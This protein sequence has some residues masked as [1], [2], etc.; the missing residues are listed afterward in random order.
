L[1]K[2]FIM[3]NPG[4]FFH[5]KLPTTQSFQETVATNWY[6]YNEDFGFYA[7]IAIN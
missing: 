6:Y 5:P 3:I 2:R 4:Y 7:M 1:E